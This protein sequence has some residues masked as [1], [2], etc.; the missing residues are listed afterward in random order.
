MSTFR[1]RSFRASTRR[2]SAPDFVQSLFDELVANFL[3]EQNKATVINALTSFC[4]V[5][6]PDKVYAIRVKMDTEFA[7]A[8]KCKY[9]YPSPPSDYGC[10][11][12]EMLYDL[13]GKV[14]QEGRDL[15]ALFKHKQV[16]G[17][18]PHIMTDIDDTLYP[19]T[20]HKTYIAGSDVSWHRK[21]IYPGAK[22]FYQRFYSKIPVPYSTI[23]SATPGCAKGH[24]LHDER[25]H[26]V[27]GKFSFIQGEERVS[28]FPAY[29][30]DILRNWKSKVSG[31]PLPE[32]SGLHKMF[33]HMKFERF[34]QYC[35][36]F[37]EY[38]I[39]F[40]GD[41]GQG[42]VLAG[43]E[44]LKHSKRCHVFIHNICEDG[45]NYKERPKGS[46]KK[47][48]HYFKHYGELATIFKEIGVFNEQ[49]ESAVHRSLWEEVLLPS[50]DQFR[51]LYENL[52]V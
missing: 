35:S 44:M 14:T 52:Y 22:M 4:T 34:K 12:R 50:N 6:N 16:P 46:P 7:L 17:G 45:V 37:P 24:K 10:D 3:K 19:N 9:C 5:N 49:D 48:M 21:K 40:I 11:L 29:S 20:E 38:I 47:R 26:S 27:L 2:R 33:G 32:L 15:L 43:T 13:Q 31:V 41:D 39:Y 42:D 1:R 25:L 18:I 23:L 8:A 28:A 51:H 30:L 36:L